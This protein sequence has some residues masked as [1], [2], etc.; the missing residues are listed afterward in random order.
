MSQWVPI[1]RYLVDEILLL[2]EVKEELNVL[3]DGLNKDQNIAAVC[4]LLSK[5]FGRP[6]RRKPFEQE[7]MMKFEDDEDQ[8]MIQFKLSHDLA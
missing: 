1:P 6:V 7:L 2:P 4:R 8:E 5:Y 3:F